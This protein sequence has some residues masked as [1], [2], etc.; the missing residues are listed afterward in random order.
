MKSDTSPIKR[1]SHSIKQTCEETGLG[2]TKVYELIGS[3]A[4]KSRRVGRRRIV[5]DDELC[6]F[7]E[8]L[9]TE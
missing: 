4:L 9:P 2:K 5:L 7:L 3:G 1:K 8:S 6:E